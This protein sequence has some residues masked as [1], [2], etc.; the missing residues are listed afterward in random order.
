MAN[1]V[2][3][4]GFDSNGFLKSLL[5]SDV[6]PILPKSFAEVTVGSCGS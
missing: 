1:P 4:A 5:I 3:S 6:Q 2:R